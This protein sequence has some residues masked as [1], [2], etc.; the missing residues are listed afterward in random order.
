MP[1]SPEEGIGPARA[2]GWL[3]DS[4]VLNARWNREI[5]PHREGDFFDERGVRDG[6]STIRVKRS[7]HAMVCF[8]SLG[9]RTAIR[10][11]SLVRPARNSARSS[12]SCW[13]TFGLPFRN[14]HTGWHWSNSAM[15]RPTTTL[16]HRRENQRGNRGLT[17]QCSDSCPRI[18][19][20]L[21]NPWP[22]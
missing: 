7:I 17:V 9:P 6:P 19:P 13:M 5:V 8:S 18:F 4:S 22:A 10:Y 11:L 20:E 21:Q 15:V 1:R 16:R 12:F 14:S 3:D 2:G